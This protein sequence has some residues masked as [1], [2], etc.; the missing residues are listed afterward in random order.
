MELIGIKKLVE[1]NSSCWESV[2]G[3]VLVVVV[4]ELVSADSLAA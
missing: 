3:V 4:S 2:V 1:Y